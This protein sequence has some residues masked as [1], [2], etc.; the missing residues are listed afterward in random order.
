MVD[1]SKIDTIKPF[2]NKPPHYCNK[3]VDPANMVGAQASK[4][5]VS[6]RLG[7][8]AENATA[9]DGIA[10]APLLDRWV[11]CQPNLDS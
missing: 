11:D 7:R 2:A 4:A 10:I 5:P 6:R 9:L 3:I 1:G 8:A